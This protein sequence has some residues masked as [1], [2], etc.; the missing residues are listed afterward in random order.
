M[1]SANVFL[2]GVIWM[3]ERSLVVR[4]G[5][6]LGLPELGAGG[7]LAFIVVALIRDGFL[8]AEI[9]SLLV[10]AWLVAGLVLLLFAVSVGPARDAARTQPAPL[11]R[12]D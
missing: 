1:S 3:V 11:L 10:T 2:P 4:R 6:Q 5:L 8:S 7:L 9:S 12:E